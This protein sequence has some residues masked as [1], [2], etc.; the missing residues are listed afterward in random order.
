MRL[1]K[2]PKT[3][4]N[5]SA[6]PTTESKESTEAS[7]ATKPASKQSILAILLLPFTLVA[8]VFSTLKSLTLTI[9]WAA[10]AI[11][12]LLFGFIAMGVASSAPSGSLQIAITWNTFVVLTAGF[13]VLALL[14][15]AK[16]GGMALLER[17]RR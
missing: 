7:S 9:V 8:S 14:D 12:A 5:S 16:D 3:A 13:L 15:L 17:F 10:L 6:Q 11:L 2:Q 4:S 1:G